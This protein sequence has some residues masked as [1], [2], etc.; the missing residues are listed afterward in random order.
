MA[1]CD[2]SQRDPSPTCV[3]IVVMGV[4]GTGKS[5][6]GSVIAEALN[7]PYV[8]G[9]EL[10]PK[11]NVEKMAA[12][13]PLN[14]A[15]REPW[16][17]LIRTTAEHM[18]VEQRV[19]QNSGLGS[20]AASGVVLSC[21]ALKKYYRD[22]LRGIKKPASK[23]QTLPSHLEPANPDVLRTYFVFIDGS[24][25]VLRDRMEKRPGH[26]MKASML[27]SQLKTLESPVGEEGV[28]V[29]SLEDTTEV[30]LRMALEGL[31]ELGV[32]VDR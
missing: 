2:G 23:G 7:M 17:E 5:T 25:E 9:D 21:S 16:L 18:V 19:G 15:D 8:E 3:A 1:P 13:H 12:G 20:G 32:A 31:R 29:L 28:V 30:Q 14:D 24:R 6:L 11:S 10:H 26:F 22:I 27:D 4:S